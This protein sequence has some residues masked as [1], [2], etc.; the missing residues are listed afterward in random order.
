M[1]SSGKAEFQGAGSSGA[2]KLGPAGGIYL[3]R[4]PAVA[5]RYG[6]NDKGRGGTGGSAGSQAILVN[7][8][9]SNEKC[10]AA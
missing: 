1:V 7:R 4:I 5:S 10:P 9:L 2:D 3:R 6:G 8:P